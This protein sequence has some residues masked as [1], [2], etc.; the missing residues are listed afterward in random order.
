MTSRRWWAARPTNAASPGRLRVPRGGRGRPSGL[1]PC[2]ALTV[3]VGRVAAGAGWVAEELGQP[4]VG[5]EHLLIAL[6]RDEGCG[7]AGIFAQLGVEPAV[8]V[9]RPCPASTDS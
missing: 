7:A 3:D 4:F 5:V 1:G 2:R 8:L 6:I 9:E